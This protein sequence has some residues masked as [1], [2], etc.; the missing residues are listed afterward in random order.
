[1]NIYFIWYSNTKCKKIVIH[2]PE[3]N[4]SEQKYNENRLSKNPNY[5]IH[6]LQR[7]KLR[8]LQRKK[9]YCENL[10]KQKKYIAKVN[11]TVKN[12]IENIQSEN[13]IAQFDCV[14]K[15]NYYFNY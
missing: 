14:K 7:N 9:K 3:K 2:N 12:I 8:L 5:R 15:R 10:L 13:K 11:P 1:M 6:T 4:L